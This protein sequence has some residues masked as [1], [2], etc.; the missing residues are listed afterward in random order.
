MLCFEWEAWQRG[1]MSTAPPVPL[2]D[3]AALMNSITTETSLK[4]AAA[5]HARGWC[6]C[7]QPMDSA[8][9]AAML[10]LSNTEWLTRRARQASYLHHK[11]TGKRCPGLRTFWAVK[12]LKRC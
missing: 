5:L 3:T 11:P 1:R 9:V 6:R 4:F 8:Q 2:E 7:M 10:W 12:T